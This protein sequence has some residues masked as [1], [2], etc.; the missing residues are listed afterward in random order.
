MTIDENIENIDRILIYLQS[1]CLTFPVQEKKKQ[2]QKKYLDIFNK[3]CYI[4]NI[5]EIT[6]D[7][8]NSDKFS[9][10]WKS[11]LTEV[12]LLSYKDTELKLNL[13]FKTNLIVRINNY[14]YYING[15]YILL[16][17]NYYLSIVTSEGKINLEYS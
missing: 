2:V 1:S 6:L 9:G 5:Q 17:Q 13:S 8:L 16:N 12:Y 11:Y 3:T 10:C 15:E 14:N 4:P 7:Q